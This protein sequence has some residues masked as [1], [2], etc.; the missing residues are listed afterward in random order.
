MAADA[1]KTASRSS[2]A[3]RGQTPLSGDRG[4]VAAIKAGIEDLSPAYFALV[5]ATGIISIALNMLGMSAIGAALFVVNVVAYA[6]L[7]VLSACRAIW[8]SSRFFGDMLDHQQGPGFF[9]AVAASCVLGTQCLLI[10]DNLS[11]AVVLLIAG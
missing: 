4:P 1:G 10:V 9:T 8:F 3:D 6:I 5:M 7:T 11:A 2:G